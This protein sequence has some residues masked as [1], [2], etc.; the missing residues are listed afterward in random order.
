MSRLYVAG[1]SKLTQTHA[2]D[3]A[4]CLWE[5][6]TE[7][8]GGR[9]TATWRKLSGRNRRDKTAVTLTGCDPSPHTAFLLFGPQLAA[10]GA[11]EPP[12]PS[13][14]QSRSCARWQLR[15]SVCARRRREAAE[16]RGGGTLVGRRN[17]LMMP[18]LA[19]SLS[20]P[21][22]HSLTPLAA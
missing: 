3:D 15:E 22:T 13:E 5:H 21:L 18:P 12:P 19:H 9:E 1:R 11:V 4:S 6:N 17:T 20:P 14:R 2:A 8:R 7:R 10:A 16:V